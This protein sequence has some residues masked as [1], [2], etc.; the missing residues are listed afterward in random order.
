MAAPTLFHAFSSVTLGLH[1]GGKTIG[2]AT[3]FRCQETFSQFAIEILG[4][5]YVQQHEL[6]GVRN[7][8]SFDKIKLNMEALTSLENDGGPIWYNQAK[9]TS[10]LLQLEIQTLTLSTK[11]PSGDIVGLIE[12]AGFKPESRVWAAAQGSVMTENISFVCTKIK[13]NKEPIIIF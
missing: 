2:W 11:L 1:V 6:T 4:D 12:I 7:S 8:G 13:E 3:G 10:G 9:D 5:A